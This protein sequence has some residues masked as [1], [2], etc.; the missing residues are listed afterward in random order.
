MGWEETTKDPVVE[1]R[2][3][4]GAMRTRKDLANPAVRVHVERY[5][6]EAESEIDYLAALRD[7]ASL[8]RQDDDRVQ[9]AL[10][11]ARR[12]VRLAEAKL[13]AAI[14][15]ERGDRRAEAEANRRA[16]EIV[17]HL[18]DDRGPDLR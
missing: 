9:L 15:E 8:V 10:E 16:A 3:A 6:V 14:A 5:L 18:D 7:R 17:A 2:F 11:R 12:A 4:L 13:D 1:L